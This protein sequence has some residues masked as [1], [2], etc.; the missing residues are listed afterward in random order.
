MHCQKH[1]PPTTPATPEAIPTRRF[2]FD[3]LDWIAAIFVI[4]VPVFI[5]YRL[6]WN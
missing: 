5:A 4:A 6:F 3:V 2:R 1:L